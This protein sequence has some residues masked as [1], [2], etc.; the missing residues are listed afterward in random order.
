[1]A[2]GK[3]KQQA[4]EQV[5]GLL[6]QL[7]PNMEAQ[8]HRR[9][10]KEKKEREDALLSELVNVKAKLIQE[11]EEH[12]QLRMKCCALENKLG[13]WEEFFKSALEA[14]KENLRLR[15]Q[16]AVAGALPEVKEENCG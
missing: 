11:A 7:F 12:Q 13:R 1:M 8:E 2:A 10:Q 3:K 4:R 15:E 9:T 6:L 5:Q 16:L 14:K